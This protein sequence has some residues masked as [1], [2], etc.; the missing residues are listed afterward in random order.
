MNLRLTI[1]V[2]TLLAALAAYSA[3]AQESYKQNIGKTAFNKTNG[4]EIG[5]IVDAVQV[6]GRWVYKVNRD[7]RII[8]SPVD[9][10]VVKTVPSTV[11]KDP[12][13]VAAGAKIDATLA[14]TAKEFQ[15]RLAQ[16]GGSLQEMTLTAGSLKAHWS[17][18][19]CDSLES[20]VFDLLLSVNR[21]LKTSP[22]IS[23]S[24]TCGARNATYT[25]SGANLQR[26][27]Q[28]KI[29][30]AAALKGITSR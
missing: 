12:A 28:G 2:M 9:N 25:L 5:K 14:P 8:N 3:E 6:N 23:A 15:G 11:A 24:R 7:G 22:N 26:Y 1:G 20:E 4:V 16:Y 29:N 18:S 13:P 10:V 27:R 30:D 17:S 19:K 21:T